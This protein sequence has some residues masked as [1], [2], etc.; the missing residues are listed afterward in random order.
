MNV[1]KI[2][3]P[4]FNKTEF[5][6]T[7]DKIIK[8]NK[9]PQLIAGT[10]IIHNIFDGWVQYPVY[11]DFSELDNK[12]FSFWKYSKTNHIYV[13]SPNHGLSDKLGIL[14]YKVV[15][16]TKKKSDKRILL[17]VE[18]LTP[19]AIFKTIYLQIDGNKVIDC[20]HVFDTTH[21]NWNEC[22][23]G[24]EYKGYRNSKWIKLDPNDFTNLTGKIYS[25]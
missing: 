1:I 19:K 3:K 21:K 15:G 18:D 2:S 9:N 14:S 8:S 25:K 7:P 17:I 10:K 20:G 12:L 13:Y 16:A 23:I 24:D 4:S 22:N 6:G 11:K 5:N